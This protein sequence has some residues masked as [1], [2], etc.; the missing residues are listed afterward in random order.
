[1]YPAMAKP[2][3]GWSIVSLWTTTTGRACAD[4]LDRRSVRREKIEANLPVATIIKIGAENRA[5]GFF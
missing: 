4:T 1:M 5:S 3:T 2:G